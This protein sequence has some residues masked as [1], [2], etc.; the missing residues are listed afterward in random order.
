MRG[1]LEPIAWVRLVTGLDA[2]GAVLQNEVGADGRSET[3][4][5]G[6]QNEVGAGGG[7]GAGVGLVGFELQAEVAGGL[8]FAQL[9]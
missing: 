5:T 1:T 2:G 9:G 3:F 4:P 8:Q 7:S 6:L